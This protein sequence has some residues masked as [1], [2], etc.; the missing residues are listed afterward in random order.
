MKLPAKKAPKTRSEKTAERRAERA[1]EKAAEKPVEK[2]LKAA[3]A[4]WD[5]KLY[6]LRA[7][8]L[9]PPG[10]TDRLKVT[11]A[12]GHRATVRVNKT[13]P[14]KTRVLFVVG[15]KYEVIQNI[16]MFRFAQALA[17]DTRVEFER[18][19]VLEGGRRV[20][21]AA[22]LETPPA[23]GIL[24]KDKVVL[25]LL[26]CSSHDGSLALT[27]GFMPVRV[28]CSNGLGVPLRD[29]AGRVKIL[30]TTS[31][32]ERMVLAQEAI[33]QALKYY[34]AFGELAELLARTR[35]ER[36][37]L[38][39]LAE[40][41]YPARNGDVSPG[42]G[43]AREALSAAFE[44]RAKPMRD[45]AET[46]WSAWNAVAESEDYRPTRS[47]EDSLLASIL[48]GHRAHMKLRALR[49]IGR[50]AKVELPL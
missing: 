42:A 28:L 1:I 13:G 50:L 4:D 33:G 44:F 29:N 34:E 35:F 27:A 38:T 6:D 3:G 31:W 18:A 14:R 46:A 32:P 47:S 41:L 26:V 37:Q 43:E 5:V 24:A 12:T 36:E 10:G 2:A 21:L 20:W 16:E 49:E 8:H 17:A 23:T 22:T 25:Y 19:G 40:K 9:E 7:E 15:K 11:E 45:T 48:W 30:H 39:Q